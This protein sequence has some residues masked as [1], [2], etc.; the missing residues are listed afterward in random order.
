MPSLH[1]QGNPLSFHISFII[2]HIPSSSFIVSVPYIH[3]SFA[4]S[5]PPRDFP[6]FR[7]S[8]C[9]VTSSL[10]I[11][12]FPCSILSFSFLTVFS[13]AYNNSIECFHH[14]LILI[15]SVTLSFSFFRDGVLLNGGFCVSSFWIKAGLF[16]FQTEIWALELKNRVI[17]HN[18]DFSVSSWSVNGKLP[19][20][21]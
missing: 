8:I 15:A 9:L 12:S 4:L 17:R 13:I 2:P 18:T 16:S 5:S 19:A 20:H 14:C 3:A 10:L 21:V 11:S 6:L 7:R 1:F